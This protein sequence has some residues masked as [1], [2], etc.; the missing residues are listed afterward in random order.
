MQGYRYC[1]RRRRSALSLPKTQ[2]VNLTVK[3]L[4]S[5]VVNAI[6]SREEFM[7][8][9][10]DLRY[11]QAPP[12]AEDQ[13]MKK[14]SLLV[15]IMTAAL[16]TQ[17]AA[18][19]NVPP[20]E[21]DAQLCYGYAMVGY[22]SVINSRLGVPAEYALGLAMKNPIKEAIDERFSINVLKVA[23][24]AYIWPGNPH[25]YAVQVMYRCAKTQGNFLDANLDW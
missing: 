21:K 7:T 24:N 13:T 1:S 6:K 8:S 16:Y 14:F 9:R 23:L 17:A 3:T 11:R 15:V 10:P 19:F 18:A 2:G 4:G 22:D 12:T 20:L 25:D 5:C